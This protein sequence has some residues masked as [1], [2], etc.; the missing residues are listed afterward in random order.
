MTT[1]D[2]ARDDLTAKLSDGV[3]CPCCGQ[4]AKAYPRRVTG[5]AAASLIRVFREHGH[6]WFRAAGQHGVSALGG[7]FARMAHWG[8]IQEEL[9]ARPDGGRSGWWRVTAK[10]AQFIRSGLTIPKTVVLYDNHIIRF[11]GPMV[12]IRQ[13]LGEK[14]NYAVL[15]GRVSA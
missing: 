13:A 10:G 12:T 5:G 14:F 15:M 11:E 3:T 4:F 1:L 7:E 6:D 9:T 2:E 8:L